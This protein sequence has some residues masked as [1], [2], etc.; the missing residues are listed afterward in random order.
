M[1]EPLSSLVT[2][3]PAG[4]TPLRPDD[5]RSS[6]SL[7]RQ[8]RKSV[9]LCI[10]E[11]STTGA[12]PIGSPLAAKSSRQAIGYH[13]PRNRRPPSSHQRRS[14]RAYYARRCHRQ[15][16]SPPAR[17]VEIADWQRCRHRRLRSVTCRRHGTPGQQA[18]P[19]AGQRACRH[20]SA[21]AVR[22][23]RRLHEATGTGK[24]P[25]PAL[26]TSP[27]HPGGLLGRA[28]Q[29]RRVSPAQQHSMS[30]ERSR[31]PVEDYDIAATITSDHPER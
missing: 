10:S 11:H 26:R 17:T 15:D 12:K 13:S 27:R 7:H 5:A 3:R 19:Y 4:A 23:S 28:G 21:T 8:A 31:Q 29:A 25:T 9:A 14:H 30:G 2:S 1:E 24:D 18:G 6:A 22:Q 20:A 16:G